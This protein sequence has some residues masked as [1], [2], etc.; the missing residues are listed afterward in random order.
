MELQ[1]ALLTRRSV[2]TYENR[3]VEKEKLDEMINAAQLAPSW[4]NSQ[5]SRYYIAQ[6]KALEAVRAALP[7][8]NQARVR[9]ASV[10][11]VQTFVTGCSGFNADGTP[12]NELGDGWGCY[13]AGLQ[14]MCMLLKA[15]ELGLSSLIMGFRD[16]TALREALDIPESEAVI[17]VIAVGYSDAH[18]A[19]KQRKSPEEI[20][21]FI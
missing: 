20:A 10:L 9:D 5:T 11:I 1:Q 6:G 15:S 14:A 7:E 16:A 13:D 2:R 18:P 12:T 4:K 19:I 17:S 21:H 3:P 8:S